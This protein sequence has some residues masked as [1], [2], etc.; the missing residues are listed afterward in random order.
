MNQKLFYNIL[1][2]KLI[3]ISVKRG[4]LSN[5]IQGIIY[6]ENLRKIN[7]KFLYIKY[8]SKIELRS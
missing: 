8:S 5:K 4:M 1:K 3:K 7:K 2:E 6:S